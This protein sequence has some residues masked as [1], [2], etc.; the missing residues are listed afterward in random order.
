MYLKLLNSL[1]KNVTEQNYIQS[2]LI[3]QLDGINT[4]NLQGYWTDIIG[5]QIF[6]IGGNVVRGDNYYYFPATGYAADL[7]IGSSPVDLVATTG[8]FTIEIVAEFDNPSA[9]NHVF[10]GG[11]DSGLVFTFANGTVVSRKALDRRY[12]MPSASGIRT[13]SYSSYRAL[14]NKVVCQQ[15][16]QDYWNPGSSAACVGGVMSAP[17]RMFKGKIYCIRLYNR[18]LSVQEVLFNQD[19]DYIR[20]GII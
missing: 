14:Q 17:A 15:L 5:G 13:I 9:V 11:D 16:T 19:I 18:E 4:G 20:F 2:G 1:V 7:C 8:G 12:T 3:F 10:H 6:A